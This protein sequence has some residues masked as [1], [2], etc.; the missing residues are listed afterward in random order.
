MFEK[1]S[2]GL[3]FFGVAYMALSLF[4]LWF[5]RLLITK[6][7]E[8]ELD[9]PRRKKFLL[10]QRIN[11]LVFGAVVVFISGLPDHLLLWVGVPLLLAVLVSFAVCNKR[12][13]GWCLPWM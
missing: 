7:L 8:G 5:P 12:I 11:M 2:W 1:V 13:T 10:C 4:S 3:L 6:K 9:E